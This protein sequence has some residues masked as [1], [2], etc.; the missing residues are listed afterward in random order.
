MVDVTGD[1]GGQ[2]P[3]LGLQHQ[4]DAAAV[5]ALPDFWHLRLDLRRWGAAPIESAVVTP[6]AWP[7]ATAPLRVD[8]VLDDDQRAESAC[9][10]L[11]RACAQAGRTVA[12]L[13]V[14]PST[15]RAVRHAR[16]C[17]PDARIGGGTAFFFTN[18]NR[19]TLPPGID[20]VSYTTCPI[21]HVADDCSVMQSLATLT[22]QVQTLRLCG[23]DAPVRL[24][25]IGIGMALDPFGVG[26]VGEPHARLAMARD[27]PRDRSAFGQAWMLAYLCQMVASGVQTLTVAHAEAF[28]PLQPLAG[29]SGCRVMAL[30]NPQ[31]DQLAVLA[32]RMGPGYQVWAANL[33]SAPRQLVLRLPGRVPTPALPLQPH[34]LACHFFHDPDKQRNSP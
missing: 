33:G 32:L 24:G 29:R 16:A 18:L 31:P 10:A 4:P 34:A 6:H 14:F 12:E 30:H 27:D 22:T 25:P 21:I 19:L 26:V 23:V 5:D 9:R 2:L 8:L 17:F 11:A 15:P 20:F 3:A 28:R 1:D 7:P 13:A